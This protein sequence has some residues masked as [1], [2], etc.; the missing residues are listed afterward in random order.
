MSEIRYGNFKVG[1]ITCKA[2]RRNVT[3]D[4]YIHFLL[5]NRSHKN[6]SVNGMPENVA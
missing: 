2:T 5:C 3:N 6:D 1:Y 4:F